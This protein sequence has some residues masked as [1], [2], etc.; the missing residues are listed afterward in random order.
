MTN[1]SLYRSFTISFFQKFLLEGILA[2]H[3]IF[4]PSKISCYTVTNKYVCTNKQCHGYG[5][6]RCAIWNRI[7]FNFTTY[8]IAAMF[9]KG[10]FGKWTQFCQTIYKTIKK[11]H[12]NAILYYIHGTPIR[13]TFC[14]SIYQSITQTLSPPNIPAI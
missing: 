13:Q 4:V 10:E 2:L 7:Q 11:S 14:Q 6:F 8:L 9:G 3:Q 12:A 1:L 5:K